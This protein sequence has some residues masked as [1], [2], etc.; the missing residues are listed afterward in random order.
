M[1]EMTTETY[2]A[3]PPDLV[4]LKL[5]SLVTDKLFS[6]RRKEECFMINSLRMFLHAIGCA[7]LQTYTLPTEK[8]KKTEHM[9]FIR[10]ALVL[11]L[12]VIEMINK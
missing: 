10:V 4:Q 7:Y 8:E 3:A 9:P 5:F 12:Y 2:Y 1:G 6:N 11:A